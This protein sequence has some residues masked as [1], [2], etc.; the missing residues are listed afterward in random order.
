MELSRFF[1]S[2]KRLRRSGFFKLLRR[3][4]SFAS[5]AAAAA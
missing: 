1:F 5:P 4:L 3:F 2:M